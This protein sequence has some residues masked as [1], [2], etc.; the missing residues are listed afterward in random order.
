MTSMANFLADPAQIDAILRAG[1][2][3]ANAIAQPILKDTKAAVGF[4]S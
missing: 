1:A 2:D 4:W 3:R